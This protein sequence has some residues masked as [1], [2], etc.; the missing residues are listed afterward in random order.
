MLSIRKRIIAPLPI[1]RPM[2]SPKSFHKNLSTLEIEDEAENI[3]L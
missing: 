2:I 1:P 3:S